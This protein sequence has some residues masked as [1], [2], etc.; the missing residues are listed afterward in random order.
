MKIVIKILVLS[1]FANF[2]LLANDNLL[3]NFE[4]KRVSQN[5]NVKIKDIKLFYKQELDL[6]NWNAYILEINATIGDKN[7][8]VKDILFSDG[9]VIV[10]NLYDIKSGKSFKDDVSPTLT[11]K[12]YQKSKLIAGDEKA[13]NKIVIFSDPLCKSCK[14]YIPEIINFVNQN[15]EQIALYYYSFPQK[16]IHAASLTLSKLINIAKVKNSNN[17]L[18]KAYNTNWAKHFEVTQTDEQVILE[19]FN[20]E[21]GLD[22]KIEELYKRAINTTIEKDIDMAENI[23]VNS[24]P[25]IYINGKKDTTKDKYKSLIKKTKSK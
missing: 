1:L 8:K 11:K 3:I 16:H 5:Q 6:K 24:T 21:L 19:A 17:I 18:I 14:K 15:S 22:I 2:I 9:K 12:Y 7:I 13:K 20:K 23:L 4:K 25:T 10:T